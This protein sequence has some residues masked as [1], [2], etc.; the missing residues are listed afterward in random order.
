MIYRGIDFS[1]SYMTSGNCKLWCTFDNEFGG[2][3]FLAERQL[4]CLEYAGEQDPYIGVDSDTPLAT[5]SRDTNNRVIIDL[6]EWLRMQHAAEE[7][8]E[9]GVFCPADDDIFYLFGSIANYYLCD[10]F[11][12]IIPP[13]DLRDEGALIV[14]P[15]RALS[16]EIGGLNFLWW[17]NRGGWQWR[18]RGTDHD[19]EWAELHNGEVIDASEG[20]VEI[21]DGYVSHGIRRRVECERLPC[22]VRWAYLKWASIVGPYKWAVFKISEQKISSDGDYS[23]LMQDNSYNEVKGREDSLTLMIDKLDT[24]DIWYYS[25][26]LTS[27]DVRLLTADDIYSAPF[28]T[29]GGKVEVTTN[30]VTAPSGDKANGKI[31]FEI[32]VKRYDAISM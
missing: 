22:G 1:G 31:E 21:F 17:D 7:S 28:G 10:P 25:D 20:R 32:K 5:Y 30:N 2:N 15:S 24:Y 3:I 26:I 4:V 8:P 6:T 14:P 27:S 18:I 13:T 23:L 19:T 16:C 9:I 12:M 29:N 11:R